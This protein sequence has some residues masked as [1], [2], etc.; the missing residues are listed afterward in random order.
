MRC[1]LDKRKLPEVKSDVNCVWYRHGLGMVK[2]MY[3]R[4]LTS[5]QCSFMTIAKDYVLCVNA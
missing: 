5:T 4:A 3:P 2:N 1:N